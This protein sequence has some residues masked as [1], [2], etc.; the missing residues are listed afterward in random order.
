MKKNVHFIRIECIHINCCIVHT[1]VKLFRL[2]LLYEDSR[3][4]NR[5]FK[6]PK[7]YK[8]K[9]FEFNMTFLRIAWK[10]KP[11]QYLF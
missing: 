1:V 5:D 6:S 3:F 2:S 11:D 4:Q 7:V 8:N 10:V 9:D